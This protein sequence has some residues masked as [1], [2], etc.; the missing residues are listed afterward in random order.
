MGMQISCGVHP[1]VSE[2]G[3]VSAI[4]AGTGN[5]VSRTGATTGERNYRGAPD[6]GSCAHVDLDSAE[7]FGVIADGVHERQECDSHRA[8]VCWAAQRFWARGYW[9]STVGKNEAAVRRYIQ[10]QEKEDQR[11]D[12]MELMPL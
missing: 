11:L 6:A 2:E 5:G 9:V 1:E 8:G 3:V 4:E 10:E 12:Q 7:A